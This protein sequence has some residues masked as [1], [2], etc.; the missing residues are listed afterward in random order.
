MA[1]LFVIATVSAVAIF[2]V[3]AMVRGKRFDA[4]TYW[5]QRYTTRRGPLHKS[6]TLA[7]QNAKDVIDVEVRELR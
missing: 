2:Y 4:R 3:V 5:N 7:K 6:S 1:L